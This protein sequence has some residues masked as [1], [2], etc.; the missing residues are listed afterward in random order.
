[1]MVALILYWEEEGFFFALEFYFYANSILNFFKELQL[2]FLVYI[3][4]LILIMRTETV[5]LPALGDTDTKSS[6]DLWPWTG[7]SVG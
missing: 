2:P 4:V 6:E 5:T 3:Q 7:S 1:M